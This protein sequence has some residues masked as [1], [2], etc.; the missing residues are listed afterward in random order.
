M[1]MFNIWMFFSAV[2]SITS[3]SSFIV[4]IFKHKQLM[5]PHLLLRGGIINF[6]YLLFY[7]YFHLLFHF[8]LSITL[9]YFI[10][11]YF[12]FCFTLFLWSL[13]CEDFM[14]LDFTNAL[15]CWIIVLVF[16]VPLALSLMHSPSSFVLMLRSLVPYYLF[17]PMLVGFF[18]AYSFARC[19]DLSWGNRPTGSIFEI[20]GPPSPSPYHS[21]RT[22]FLVIDITRCTH[23]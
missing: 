1:W 9:F 20:I 17:L 22:R 4:Y 8:I 5:D 13:I 3:V 15:A 18:G 12:I 21:A 10:L 16:V 7:F 14:D 2:L 19:W 6:T 11:L 23:T